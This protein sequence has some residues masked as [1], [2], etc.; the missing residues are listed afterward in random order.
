MNPLP[1]YSYLNKD[2][3][4]T[5]DVPISFKSSSLEAEELENREPLNLNPFEFLTKKDLEKMQSLNL[6]QFE[7]FNEKKEK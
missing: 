1:K 6:N 2:G 4:I 5:I 7:F 3:S